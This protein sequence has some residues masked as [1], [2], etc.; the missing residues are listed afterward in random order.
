[1]PMTT[2]TTSSSMRVKPSSRW[3]RWRSLDMR[4]SFGLVMCMPLLS[5]IHRGARTTHLGQLTRPPCLGPGAEGAD[6]VADDPNGGCGRSRALAYL[7]HDI[8]GSAPRSTDPL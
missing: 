8:C 2:M 6:L 7:L 1:M 4:Y 5:R 3:S